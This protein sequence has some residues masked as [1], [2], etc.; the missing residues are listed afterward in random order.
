MTRISLSVVSNATSLF[1]VKKC[2]QAK[3]IRTQRQKLSA[4]QTFLHISFSLTHTLPLSLSLS[5]F[6]YL[7][8]LQSLQ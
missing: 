1:A 6:L 8:L 5:I 2:T 3:F 7:C 4:S